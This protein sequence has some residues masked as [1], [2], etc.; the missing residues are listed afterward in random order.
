MNVYKKIFFVFLACLVSFT[1]Q[2]MFDACSDFNKTVDEKINVL[3]SSEMSKTEKVN[4]LCEPSTVHYKN[5][6]YVCNFIWDAQYNISSDKILPKLT[7]KITQN[8]DKTWEADLTPRNWSKLL[9]ALENNDAKNLNLIDQ[10][11]NLTEL[12]NVISLIVNKEKHDLPF[13]ENLKRSPE[14][15]VLQDISSILE[16][17]ADNLEQINKAYEKRFST[18]EKNF[19]AIDSHITNIWQAIMQH[20]DAMHKWMRYALIVPF[21]P[22]IFIAAKKIVLYGLVH[23]RG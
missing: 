19:T 6:G 4:M 11:G 14:T 12:F 1:A 16:N 8:C 21:I 15:D 13:K 7:V 10:S 3:V 17:T 2:G 22:S 9:Q 20:K 23:L 18:I 5:L